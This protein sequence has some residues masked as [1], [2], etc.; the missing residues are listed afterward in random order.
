V[1]LQGIEG[2]GVLVVGTL[3]MILLNFGIIDFI[4]LFDWTCA[5]IKVKL[6]FKKCRDDH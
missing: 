2:V 3:P 5:I 6:L 1:I 4:D